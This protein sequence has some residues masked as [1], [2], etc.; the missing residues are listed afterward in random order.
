MSSD[1]LSMPSSEPDS[2]AYPLSLESTPT[3]TAPT[4]PRQINC[5]ETWSTTLD[6]TTPEDFAAL[7]NEMAVEDASPILDISGLPS[8][9]LQSLQHYCHGEWQSM[10]DLSL[11]LEA[12]AKL[13]NL[14]IAAGNILTGTAIADIQE[15]R[16]VHAWERATYADMDATAP[17]DLP[18][19]TGIVHHI[20]HFTVLY[21]CQEYWT[22]LDPLTVHRRP[23]HWM[24]EANLHRSLR[25][26]YQDHDIP[27]PSLP[28]YRAL[29]RISI[30]NDHPHQ[31]SCGTVALLTLIHLILGCPPPHKIRE[32]SISKQHTYRFHQT[33]LKWYVQGRIPNIWEDGCIA[34]PVRAAGPLEPV[35][36][37]P[38]SLE[39]TITTVP[40][41]TIT[42][43]P[44]AAPAQPRARPAPER[45]QPPSH[46]RPTTRGRPRRNPEPQGPL[47]QGRSRDTRTRADSTPDRPAPER[48]VPNITPVPVGTRTS[49][50]Q[51]DIRNWARPRPKQ[52]QPMGPP[53][54][55]TPPH[56]PPRT[57]TPP[58][59]KKIP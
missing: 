7:V 51:T 2:P 31:W 18:Y 45:T 13:Y 11:C 20:N 17:L 22:I 52:T 32:N 53:P 19:M 42:F 54:P 46:P 36:N 50:Q 35:H 47:P 26:Y 48:T 23:P 37:H 8:I 15:G 29:P 40:K 14:N 6:S 28:R 27:T 56:T 39:A 9:T 4:P 59:N 38:R 12:F 58:K 3:Q 5:I 57:P 25:R 44:L 30:Q 55:P 33:V 24:P 10:H 34:T 49:L 43:A 41:G 21:I 1:S 16:T